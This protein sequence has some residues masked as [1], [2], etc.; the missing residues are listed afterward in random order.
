MTIVVSAMAPETDGWCALLGTVLD[1]LREMARAVPVEKLNKTLRAV[2]QSGLRVVVVGDSGK[3]WRSS[4]NGGGFAIQVI[5]GTPVLRAVAMPAVNIAFLAGDGGLLLRSGDFG[6]TWT[7][8]TSGTAQRL[9]GLCFTDSLQGWACGAAGTL[10]RTTDGGAT[11]APVTSGTAQ[12]LFAVSQ[13]NNELWIAGANGAV[14][15]EGDRTLLDG[16]RRLS[17]SG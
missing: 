17:V 9:N 8:Q 5:S 16:F 12:E 10:L 7:P 4:D 3:V 1:V 2:A 11:W 15:K 14:L 6:A 13:L